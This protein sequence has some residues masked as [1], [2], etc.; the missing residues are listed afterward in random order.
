MVFN[1]ID[2][3]HYRS[4]GLHRA[5]DKGYI[6]GRC[7]NTE[8]LVPGTFRDFFIF[9]LSALT[10]L[11]NV[12]IT[13][14]IF[15]VA[16]P[17]PSVRPLFNGGYNSPNANANPA[18]D[19]FEIFDITT[20]LATVRAGSAAG[21]AAGTATYN[22]LGTGTSYSSYTLTN[23]LNTPG[24][25]T[26]VMVFNQDGVTALNGA[27]DPFAATSLFGFGGRFMDLDRNAAN[28]YILRRSDGSELRRL[29]IEYQVLAADAVPEPSTLGLSGFA[30]AGLLAWQLS[31][32]FRRWRV[33]VQGGL[34][35]ERYG[36]LFVAGGRLGPGMCKTPTLPARDPGGAGSL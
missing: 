34:S 27:L 30:L 31:P 13:D 22:D 19:T 33:L 2:S 25:N 28:Q 4:D 15:T 7:A 24:N 3:G 1:A 36:P 32:R 12:Q 21:S 16:N 10:L 35:S 29:T 17:L 20:G 23:S 14:A 9:D 6:A 18:R 26:L 11:G 5:N 8:C